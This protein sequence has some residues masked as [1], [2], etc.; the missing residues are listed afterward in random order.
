L[1]PA[2]ALPLACAT[3]SVARALARTPPQLVFTSAVVD[4]RPVDRIDRV[5]P[6]TAALCL[7]GKWFDLP[8]TT[9]R[10]RYEL[11]DAAGDVVNVG[12]QEITATAATWYTWSCYQPTPADAPGRWTYVLTLGDATLDGA[13]EVDPREA[14][15]LGVL[16]TGNLYGES[17]DDLVDPASAPPP[18]PAAAELQ[19]AL[20]RCRQEHPKAP[21]PA[22][23][24]F[25]IAPEGALVDVKAEGEGPLARCLE[26]ALARARV[27]GGRAEPL[28][29]HLPI[30]G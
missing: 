19:A 26:S 13:I 14:A 10:Y 28:R 21:V 9:Q 4:Q 16:A 29:V 27:P 24:D 1:L 30:G 6:D 3:A 11:R 8:R 25:T 2:L 22:A 12:E 7:S 20:E 17:L 5:G 23:L 18:N 15:V